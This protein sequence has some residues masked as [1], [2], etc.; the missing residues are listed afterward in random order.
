M[1]T[2]NNFELDLDY[3]FILLSYWVMESLKGS[4]FLLKVLILWMLMP[5]NWN[6][7]IQWT[8]WELYP[9]RGFCFYRLSALIKGHIAQLSLFMKM[10]LL[11]L[12]WKTSILFCNIFQII[13]QVLDKT[14]GSWFL[15]LMFNSGE[16]WLSCY[17]F[18]SLP[19]L[20]VLLKNPVLFTKGIWRLDL[21]I[22][23]QV[24][25]YTRTSK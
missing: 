1:A 7:S 10:G 18:L 8:S 11:F 2:I 12:S 25:L 20:K 24:I 9:K 4:E 21:V 14:L 22:L 3:V 23:N 13:V 6:I 19:F 5:M 16:T 17:R 15:K